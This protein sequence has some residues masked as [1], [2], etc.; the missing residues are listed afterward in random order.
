MK[1]SS[2]YS[3]LALISIVAISALPVIAKPMQGTYIPFASDVSLE[4]ESNRFRE[5]ADLETGAGEWQPLSNLKEIKKGVVYYKL[6]SASNGQYYCLRSSFTFKGY[7][8][9][10]KK[11]VETRKS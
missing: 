10:T 4:I 5:G 9:C 1:L 8:V 11:G 7:Q 3:S 2:L 6:K